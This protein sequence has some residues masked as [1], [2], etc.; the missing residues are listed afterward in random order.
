MSRSPSLSS[1]LLRAL[2]LS[3]SLAIQRNV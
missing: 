3:L 1:L 2:L